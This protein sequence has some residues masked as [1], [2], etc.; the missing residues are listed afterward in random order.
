MEMTLDYIKDTATEG[1]AKL[2]DIG[3]II[4][5]AILESRGDLEMAIDTLEGAIQILE[6]TRIG[7]EAREIIQASIG[8]LQDWEEDAA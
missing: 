4:T 6:K 2:S 1:N 7:K 8:Y 3:S 5:L